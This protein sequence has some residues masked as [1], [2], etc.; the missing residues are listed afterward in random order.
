MISC[1]SSLSHEGITSTSELLPNDSLFLML[2]YSSTKAKRTSQPHQ[3]RRIV[4]ELFGR[5]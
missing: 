3:R 2:Q 4:T 5:S 1:M